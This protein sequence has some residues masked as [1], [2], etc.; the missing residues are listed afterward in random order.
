MATSSTLVLFD[1]DGTLLDTGGAGRRTF[2]TALDAT[3]DWD[4]DLSAIA[5]AGATDLDLVERLARKHGH[6][7]TQEDKAAF[8]N[9]L[10]AELP[11][12]LAK[13]NTQVFPGVRELLSALGDDPRVTLGLVTGNIETCAWQK[14]ES[15]NLHGHFLLGA[16]GHE[17]GDRK[18]IARLA[19]AR[20]RHHAAGEHPF[21][22]IW[23]IGDTPSDIAAAHAI[24]ARAIAVATGSFDTARL[25]EA[26]ADH[27]LASLLPTADVLRTLGH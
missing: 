13:E 1:I 26:G 5:F 27:V 23:L 19:L 4:E 12:E 2:R 17:H 24:G 16:F 7:L 20:A 14:L 25:A 15:A 22:A 6:V 3:F 11:R 21:D 8:F 10:A 18:E 9:Q